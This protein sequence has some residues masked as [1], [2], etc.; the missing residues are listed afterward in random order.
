MGNKSLNKKLKKLDI[1]GHQFSSS[2]DGLAK[3]LQI[4][5]LV[6]KNQNYINDLLKWDSNKNRIQNLR[7]DNELKKQR[8]AA[9]KSKNDI[10]DKA[11]KTAL[12]MSEE[13]LFKKKKKKKKKSKK[14]IDKKSKKKIDKKSKK[15]SDKKSKKKSDKKS[16]KK[17]E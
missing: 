3:K 9:Q 8:E 14:K 4:K 2:A 17:S 6:D 7:V 13:K 15:K 12:I 10:W 1:M 16:K 5:N 11:E